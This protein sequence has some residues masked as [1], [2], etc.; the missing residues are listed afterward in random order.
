MG[1]PSEYCQEIADAICERISDGESL[2]AICRDEDMPN[3]ATVFRWLAAYAQFGDQYA[4][5]REAQ[6]EALADE[7]VEIA[8]ESSCDTYVD[9]NGNQRTNAEVVARSKLRVDARKWV[10]SKLLPK[11]YGDKIAVGGAEDLPAIASS[12]ALDVSGLSTAALAE[13]LAL[14]DAA[15]RE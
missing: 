3:K 4:R 13:I 1:R 8:D 10:A 15:N 7:I 14:K 2:R 5:A 12:V 9:D 6:A 11:K